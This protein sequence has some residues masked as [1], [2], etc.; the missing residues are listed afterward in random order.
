METDDLLLLLKL[1]ASSASST[2]QTSVVLGS[3]ADVSIANCSVTAAPLRSPVNRCAPTSGLKC[4][5]LSFWGCSQTLE[6]PE[7]LWPGKA[8]AFLAVRER[9]TASE[10]QSASKIKNLNIRNHN[11]PHDSQQSCLYFCDNFYQLCFGVSSPLLCNIPVNK[12]AS[13]FFYT[14][15]KFLPHFQLHRGCKEWT[16]QS[17]VFKLD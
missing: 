5:M 8:G 9:R 11:S 3:G 17:Y 15:F 12:C 16:F 4:W 2:S 1:T 6:M 13:F 10:F 14:Y 7:H